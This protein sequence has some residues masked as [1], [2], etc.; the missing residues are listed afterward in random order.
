MKGV[1]AD[2]DPGPPAAPWG[3]EA[4]RFG[5]GS[6]DTA[7]MQPDPDMTTAVPDGEGSGEVGVGSRRLKV[8]RGLGNLP[9]SSVRNNAAALVLYTGF[10]WS[11]L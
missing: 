5:E 9:A 2:Q 3:E 6:R 11:P 8:P 10:G 7:Q 1:T 4:G